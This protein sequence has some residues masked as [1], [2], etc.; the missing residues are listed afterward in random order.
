[1]LDKLVVMPVR[2]L[3]AIYRYGISPFI[4]G[5][6]RYHPS[7]SAYAEEALVTHGAVTGSWIALKR[8]VR[9][10]PWGGHGYDPVPSKEDAGSVASHHPSH[11]SSLAPANADSRKGS[12]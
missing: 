11:L 9:C 10:N 3:I 4:V 1:M 6:C 7:C 5:S 12:R 2:G 8:I